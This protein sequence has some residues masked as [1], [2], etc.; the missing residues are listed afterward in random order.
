LQDTNQLDFMV[1]PGTHPTLSEESLHELVGISA[2]QRT[3]TF[4][5]IGLLNHAWDTP[6]Q[7][8]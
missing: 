7:L 8:A 6:A 2:K 3:S 1:A 4:K 5:H